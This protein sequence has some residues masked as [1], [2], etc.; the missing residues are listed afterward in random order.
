MEKVHRPGG[1]HILLVEDEI[2]LR[3][4]MEKM[5]RSL[6]Y[7]VSAAANGGEAL[8]LVEEKGLLPDLLITDV[9]MPVMSGRVLVERLRRT[10]PD[11]R[12]LYMS[13][14][15]DDAIVHHGVL[16]PGTPFIQKP[17]NMQDLVTRIEL[18]LRVPQ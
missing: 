8:L 5:L 18:V 13:G 1:E 12:V 17:F 6:K 10:R 9:V 3:M 15:T 11:L 14:Y 7:R 2:A 4:L 16:E